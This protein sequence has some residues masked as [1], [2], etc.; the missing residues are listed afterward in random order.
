MA[1]VCKHEIWL[2]R[3]ALLV[4]SMLPEDCADAART[5]EY[6]NE[7]MN[8]FIIAQTSDEPQKTRIM[9]IVPKEAA[10]PAKPRPDAAE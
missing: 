8:G 2:R 3:Q 5:L 9:K 10:G 1:G 4:V 7:L 6:A